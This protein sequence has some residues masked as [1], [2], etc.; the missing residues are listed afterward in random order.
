MYCFDMLYLIYAILWNIITMQHVEITYFE[1]EHKL[2][3]LPSCTVSSD[4]VGPILN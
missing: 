1:K 2:E 3:K 4:R